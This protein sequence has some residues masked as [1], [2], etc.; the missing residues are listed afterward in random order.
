MILLS[1]LRLPPITVGLA[2]LLP[3]Q[4]TPGGRKKGAH[5]S[6]GDLWTEIID[7]TNSIRGDATRTH[8]ERVVPSPRTKHPPAAVHLFLQLS[9][10]V[11]PRPLFAPSII[12][13]CKRTPPPCPSLSPLPPHPVSFASFLYLPSPIPSFSPSLVLS[14]GRLQ[15]VLNGRRAGRSCFVNN[16]TDAR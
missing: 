16:S 6:A 15:M 9:S 14:P 10:F 5:F 4:L 13:H 7:C 1:P 8:A 12:Y 11:A 2:H 3:G